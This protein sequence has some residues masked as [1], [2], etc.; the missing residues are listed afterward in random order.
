LDFVA[1]IFSSL[2]QWR[3]WV[4]CKHMYYVL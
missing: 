1:M 4:P 2:G 3:K